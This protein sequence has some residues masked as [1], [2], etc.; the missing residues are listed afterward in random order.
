MSVTPRTSNVSK[1]ESQKISCNVTETPSSVSASASACI[2]WLFTPSGSMQQSIL[3]TSD[4]DKYIVDITQ[5][6]YLTIL[7]FQSG[8]SGTYVCRATN[9]AGSSSSYPGSTLTY[10]SKYTNIVY[11]TKRCSTDTI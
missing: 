6:P 2:T 7:N 11:A 3:R 8:D 1:D 10:I 5:E 4:S 9:A